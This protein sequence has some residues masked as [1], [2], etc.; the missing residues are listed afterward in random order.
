MQTM[1]SCGVQWGNRIWAGCRT[2]C[3][4]ISEKHV[5]VCV[6]VSYSFPFYGQC[7]GF[8]KV[9]LFIYNELM[10]KCNVLKMHLIPLFDFLLIYSL[11]NVIVV[12]I[13]LLFLPNINFQA[14]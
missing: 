4:G 3:K 12:T 7:L 6:C 13:S 8:L 2:D 14:R 11:K 1:I 5:F 10:L 9:A